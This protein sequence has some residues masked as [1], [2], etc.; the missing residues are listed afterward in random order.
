MT[1]TLT[2][3]QSIQSHDDDDFVVYENVAV[4]DEHEGDD[5]TVY[6]R[7]LL[8]Q[9]AQNCNRRIE[10][11]GDYVTV[12]V[13]HT[14]DER[15]K[16]DPPVIGFAGPFHVGRIGKKKP[17]WAI[18]GKFWIFPD[19]V[20]TFRR[21]PRRSVEVWPEETPE[22]RYFDPIAVLGAETPRR[23]LGLVYSKRNR[24]TRP[25]KYEASVAGGSNTYLPSTKLKHEK[26]DAMLQQED[27]L[28][29]IEALRPVVQQMIDESAGFPDQEDGIEDVQADEP[30]DETPPVEDD[31]PP[32]E[33]P[34][35]EEPMLN[36]KCGTNM[37][38]KYRKQRDDYKLRYQKAEGERRELA[39]KYAKLEKANNDLQGKQKYAKRVS[40]VL[41]LREQGFIV[42]TDEVDDFVGRSDA[43]WN[44]HVD[45]I[46]LKY[47]R[48]GTGLPPGAIAQAPHYVKQDA[49]Q[50]VAQAKA[51]VQKYR[52]EGK[53]LSYGKVLNHLMKNKGKLLETQIETLV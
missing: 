53:E 34:V 22:Q 15:G 17:R 28:Q 40:D 18:L 20:K 30:I 27:I 9:I 23:D 48:A 52:K 3:P 43:D 39:E 44:A 36:S 50:Y 5:G 51:E 24:M 37:Q 6:D 8:E 16:Y 4:F 33:E 25:V 7:R 49:D 38:E 31:M 13:G 10:D 11:T 29:L 35:E 19:E 47:Q 32:V 21:N 26:G 46:K 1:A 42:E 2:R 14:P 45:R 41:A 12:V